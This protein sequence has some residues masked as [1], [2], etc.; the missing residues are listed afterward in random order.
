MQAAYCSSCRESVGNNCWYWNVFFIAI[1]HFYTVWSLTSLNNHLEEIFIIEW[2]NHDTLSS[3]KTAA[4]EAEPSRVWS[5]SS[6]ATRVCTGPR[7]KP[8][9]SSQP[10]PAPASGLPQACTAVGTT[11][12]EGH[13]EAMPLTI[14]LETHGSLKPLQSVEARSLPDPE[15]SNTQMERE[16]ILNDT[17]KQKHCLVG[18]STKVGT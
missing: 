11:Q 17:W 2:H 16:R 13:G 15:T 8:P 3:L 4:A 14:L 9:R 7:G 10:F 12:E 18:V 5:L 6:T 1:F